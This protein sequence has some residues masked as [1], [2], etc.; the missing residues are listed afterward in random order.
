MTPELRG[1]TVA[2]VGNLKLGFSMKSFH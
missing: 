1:Q 2:L